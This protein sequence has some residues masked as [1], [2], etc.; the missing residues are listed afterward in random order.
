MGRHQSKRGS[1]G[2]IYSTNPEFS[3]EAPE[4]NASALPPSQQRLRVRVDTKHR[5]GKTVT[6]VEGFVGPEADLRELGKRLKTSCG[7]GGNAKEG[8]I[9]VQG[10]H[11]EQVRQ[12]LRE[13]GYGL[14]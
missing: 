10:A 14:A 8:E 9:L 3:F 1:G 2:I 13:W 7:T 12:L 6:L 4:Q 11:L 5:K